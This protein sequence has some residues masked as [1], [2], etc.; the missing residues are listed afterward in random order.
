MFLAQRK[1]IMFNQILNKIINI[2]AKYSVENVRSS[3][4]H[5]NPRPETN[6]PAL[7][8]QK[9][10]KD[11]VIEDPCCSHEKQ[12]LNDVKRIVDVM[13]KNGYYC[14]K[15]QA[16]KLWEIYSESFAAGWLLMPNKDEELFGCIKDYFKS[17]S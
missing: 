17:D 9:N 8:Q 5:T 15:Q 14:T 3:I 12:Y 11:I 2:F 13:A 6:P 4:T 7:F 10:L 16:V 1:F